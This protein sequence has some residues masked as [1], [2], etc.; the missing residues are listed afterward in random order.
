MDYRD[1]TEPDTRANRIDPVLAAAGW[2]G[3]LVRREAICPG[4]I[5]AGGKRGKGL[6]CDY[7]AILQGAETSNL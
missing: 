4:R 6:S 7:V 2:T 3:N 5:Q 1:E